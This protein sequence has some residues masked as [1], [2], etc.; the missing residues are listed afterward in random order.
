MRHA[1]YARLGG[2]GNEQLLRLHVFQMPLDGGY[3]RLAQRLQYGFQTT[4]NHIR[5]QMNRHGNFHRMNHIIAQDIVAADGVVQKQAVGKRQSL[6][7]KLTDQRVRADLHHQ[8]VQKINIDHTPAQA[9]HFNI[10]AD[11]ILFRY[12]AQD[13]AR[14]TH[15]QF[16]RRHHNRRRYGKHRQRQRL[17]LSRPNYRQPENR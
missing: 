8:R 10:V 2:R 9:V 17:D 4:Y 5:I 12:R 1:G 3:I 13:A 11:R 7:R 15:N 14:Q 16:L 6:A